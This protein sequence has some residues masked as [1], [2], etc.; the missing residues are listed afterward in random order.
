[1]AREPTDWGRVRAEYVSGN[2]SYRELSKRWGLSRT[3]LQQRATREGWYQQRLDYRKKVSEKRE[4]IAENKAVREFE[5]LKSAT[6]RALSKAEQL[7]DRYN[8]RPMP[9]R[10]LKTLS[11]ILSSLTDLTRDLHGVPP[12]PE[13]HR[14]RMAEERIQLAREQAKFEREK[15]QVGSIQIVLKGADDSDLL[16]DWGD[17]GG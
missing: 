12:Q 4:K 6:D 16:E 14:Q 1:M 15:A 13:Q 2:M 3:G 17:I 10:D 9:S 7:L 5:R 11:E 8:E